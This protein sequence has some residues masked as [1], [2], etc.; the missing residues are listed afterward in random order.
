MART[1]AEILA[2]KRNYSPELNP[3][4]FDDEDQ[5]YP[6]V[7][8]KILEI[9]DAFLDFTQIKDDVKV[10]DVR[11]VGSNASY[12]Y[13]ENSDLDIH[14]VTDLSKISKP[15]TIAQLY[16]GEVKHAFKESYDIKIKGIDVEL[17][18]EDI[19]ASAVTNGIYSVSKDEWVKEPTPM[20]D[21]SDEEIAQAEEIEDDIISRLENATDEE[22]EDIIDK[23]YVMRKDGLST[24]GEASPANLA[25]KSL[26]NKGIIQRAKDEIKK[27]V[28]KELSLESK[29]HLKE[30]LE[31][32]ITFDTK[33][34]AIEYLKGI[35]LDKYKEY[36][37]C[38][39]DNYDI[40]IFWARHRLNTGNY[41]II[42][43]DYDGVT[44]F[45]QE[46]N[47]GSDD[48]LHRAIDK[49][50]D[51]MR[52]SKRTMTSLEDLVSIVDRLDLR[53][54]KYQV[55]PDF[56][57]I[58]FYQEDKRRSIRQFIIDCLENNYTTEINSYGTHDS[59]SL[60]MEKSLLRA[61]ELRDDRG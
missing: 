2:Y 53:T 12:N 20:E 14:I 13:N 39:K 8:D 32:V 41:P 31:E 5:M 52:E 30:D 26:R 9:V 21:P 59:D 15:E 37:I 43:I 60:R 18:V 57:M 49:L 3:K 27:H 35:H 23:L 45:H 34:E 36:A 16:F 51:R 25:F 38:T 10:S 1:I 55:L 47:A 42:Q 48:L 29:R 50:S 22:K 33:A 6:E 24:E 54:L 58:G 28:S 56:Y 46:G 40:Y 11:V 44:I 19:N 61:S 7:R 4:L 17:Y